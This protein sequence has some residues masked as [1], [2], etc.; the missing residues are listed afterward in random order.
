LRDVLDLT[1]T[2]ELW[3]RPGDKWF[4]TLTLHSHP[5]EVHIIREFY[6]YLL[7]AS[8]LV[9]HECL[10]LAPNVTAVCIWHTFL[11]LRDGTK[12]TRHPEWVPL[13]AALAVPSFFYAHI[14]F[15]FHIFWPV[16]SLCFSCL[17]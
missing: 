1:Y 17:F 14:F 4:S 12:S 6:E 16:E 13:L 11:F 10:I 8:Q 7:S 9:V 15:C 2:L 3:W 5:L